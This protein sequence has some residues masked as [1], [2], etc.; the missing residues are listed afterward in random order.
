MI[1]SF[2]NWVGGGGTGSAWCSNMKLEIADPETIKLL[3]TSPQEGGPA[4]GQAWLRPHKLPFSSAGE[5]TFLLGLPNGLHG[6]RADDSAR[7]AGIRRLIW[8][9]LITE[10]AVKRQSRSDPVIQKLLLQLRDAV[11]GKPMSEWGSTNEDGKGLP[12]FILRYMHYVLFG[13]D[14]TVEQYKERCL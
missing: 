12:S 4:L 11:H 7:H 14:L 5:P 3:M 10:E 13:L 6:D 9:Y 1:G 2:H 8:K